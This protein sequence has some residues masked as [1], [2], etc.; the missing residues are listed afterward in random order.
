[1]VGGIAGVA[2][3]PKQ[4]T[5]DWLKQVIIIFLPINK[6]LI[7]SDSVIQSCLIRHTSRLKYSAQCFL[8]L[9][10][11]SKAEIF[12][13]FLSS[14]LIR[15]STKAGPAETTTQP[16]SKQLVGFLITRLILEMINNQVKSSLLYGG[17]WIFMANDCLQNALSTYTFLLLQGLY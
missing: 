12:D 4:V 6:W 17:F 9:R 3:D 15:K 14:W 5:P 16:W 8:S 10:K 11:I 7:L 2:P 13:L 1:M